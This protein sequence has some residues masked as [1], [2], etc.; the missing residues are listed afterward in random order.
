MIECDVVYQ[1]MSWNK[2]LPMIVNATFVF[3]SFYHK[4]S[5]LGFD[6]IPNISIPR[7]IK[8]Q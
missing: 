4:R 8:D 3:V 5:V 1:V 7:W 2:Y 6:T